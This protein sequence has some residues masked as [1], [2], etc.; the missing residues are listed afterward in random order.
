MTLEW[1]HDPL[2]QLRMCHDRTRGK[3]IALDR[4]RAYLPENGCDNAARMVARRLLEHFDGATPRH[5]EDEER[6]LFPRLL[7]ATDGGVAA[8]VERLHAEHRELANLWRDLRPDLAAIEAGQR[9]VLT[10]DLVRRMCDAY[11]DHLDR[12]D[13]ELITLAAERLDAHALREIGAEM[14]AHR[15]AR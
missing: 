5:D 9:S 11:F 1:R 8:L 4:L 6:S 15:A 7:E 2:L 10:P 13:S 14:A 3:L 12:E